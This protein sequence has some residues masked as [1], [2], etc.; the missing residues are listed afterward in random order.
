LF[1]AHAKC[2]CR[3]NF[4]ILLNVADVILEFE[5]QYLRAKTIKNI[6]KRVY[7][8]FREFILA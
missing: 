5:M 7:K 4:I 3:L 2:F 6:F 1:A 8:L